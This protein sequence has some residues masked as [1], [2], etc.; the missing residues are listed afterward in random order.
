VR[1]KPVLFFLAVVFLGSGILGCHSG[2]VYVNDSTYRTVEREAH[3]GETELS[4]TG[5]TLVA[6]VEK[7][8]SQTGRV[9]EELSGVETAIIGSSLEDAEKSA[10]L[11]QVSVAQAEA[12]IL[13]EQISNT[14]ADVDRLNTQLARQWEINAAL[15]V[16]HDTREAAGAEVKEELAVT[17]EKLVKV[18]GQ[19]NLAVAIAVALALAIIG[20]IVIRVL[21]FLRIIPV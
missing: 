3:R 8:D 11:H 18:S 1:R 19:R 14:R 13:T 15:S 21:R 7:I 10:L 20:F 16:E 17:K 5:T 9:I 6:D 12:S 4:I 2:P